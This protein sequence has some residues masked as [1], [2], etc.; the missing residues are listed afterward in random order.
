MHILTGPVHSGKTTYLKTIIPELREKKLQIGGYLSEAIWKNESLV[1]Y[2]LIDLIENRHLPFIRKQGL[3]EWQRIGPYYFL[4]ETLDIAKTI[5]CQC[6]SS[7]L[8]IVDEVGP[9]EL[10]GE[11][12]WPALKDALEIPEQEILIVVRESILKDFIAKIQTDDF[13]VYDIEE[14]KKSVGLAESIVQNLEKRRESGHK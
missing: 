10:K 8:C 12:V 14:N 9:L 1:G 5:I 2:D 4:P 11:G 13:V 7:D 6:K 3:Q